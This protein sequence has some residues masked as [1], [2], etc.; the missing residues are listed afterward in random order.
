MKGKSPPPPETRRVYTIGHSTRTLDELVALL[1]EFGIQCVADVRSFP[2][3]K[4]QPHFGRGHL[5]KALPAA[6]IAYVHLRGLGGYRR[7]RPDSPNRGWTSAGFR[8]YADHMRT[9]EFRQAAGELLRLA[10]ERP[11][12]VLCAE[13][14]FRRCHRQLLADWLV[15]RGYAVVHILGPGRSTTHQLTS[16]AR[17]QNGELTYPGSGNRDAAE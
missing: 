8:G 10:A 11:T 13:A 2:A 15:T 5:E 16:F 3:G 7:P 9:E 12:A 6:G 4:R 14:H 17:V 1:R